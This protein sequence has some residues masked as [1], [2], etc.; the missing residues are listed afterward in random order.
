MYT[1]IWDLLGKVTGQPVYKLLGG[2]A[3][4]RVPMY[5]SSMRRDITPEEEGE[6]LVQLIEENGFG[7]VKI[8]V[9]Q[10]MGR[11]FDA[12]P[13]R[14][15]KIIPYIRQ[16]L[17]DSID[18]H[19][20]GNSGFSA[21]GAIK[22]G[23]LMED[24]NYFHF[25]E[26]CPY[27]QIEN[28]AKV[29]DALDIAVAGGEQDMSLEQFHRMIEM[30]AVDIVQPDIGYVGGVSRARRVAYMAEA[31]GMPCTPHCANRSMLQVFSLH[32]AAAM[33]SIS[34]Y[35]EW[36]IETTGWTDGVF[37]SALEIVDGAVTM[38][39]APGWGVEIPQEFLKKAEHRV[40]K[41]G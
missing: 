40:S 13:G 21:A 20:D 36:S 5:A 14:T 30:G 26:P 18:I 19:A 7:C 6:R 4:A 24:N 2:Q 17:G 15:R 9:G 41:S 12:S 22:V 11:D 1:A 3:R 16:A 34:Q 37:E 27:P 10:V 39:E 32:L 8:R 28:T 31:A 35:Q 29:A 38:T 25:E 23:R 33:P